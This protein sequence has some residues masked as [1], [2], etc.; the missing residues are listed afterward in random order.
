MK[1]QA[2]YVPVQIDA[3][4][5][6]R[7]AMFDTYVR[8]KRWRTPAL[9]AAILS[10]FAVICFTQYS[11]RGAV[12]LGVVLLAVGLGLP[13][14]WHL[15]YELSLRTQIKRMNLKKP[16]RAYT[17]AFRPDGIEVS[18]DL[19]KTSTPLP[20]NQIAAVYRC[21]GCTYLYFDPSHAYLLPH[22]QVEGGEAGLWALMQSCLP[23]EKCFDR[24]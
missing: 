18:R 11:R 12:L 7:F 14:G 5:F 2:I 9:F 21:R 20:W 13:A 1:Q 15:S 4:T 6:H 19:G 17:L 8:Q 3:G 10:V 16:Q 23:A 24:T 22:S